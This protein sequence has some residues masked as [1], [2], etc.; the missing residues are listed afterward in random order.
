M[1]RELEIRNFVPKDFW[2][3][4]A[5]FEA[6]EGTYKGKW[7]RKEEGRDL[8]RF[9]PEEAARE[10]AERLRGKPGKVASVAA[11]TEK[12]RPELLYDLTNLQKE[13]NKRFGFTAEHTLEVAQ[14]LYEAKLISYPRTNS[15]CLTEA[16]AL[17]IPGWIRS[18]AQGQ[19]QALR[20]FVDQLRTRWPV[21]L[22]KRF[23]ND[24]EVEDHTALVPTENPARSLSGDRLRLYELIARRFLAAFWP[25]AGGGPHHGHHQDRTRRPSRPPAPWSRSWAGPRWIRPTPGP[26]RNAKGAEGESRGGRGGRDPAP[27]GQGP[28]VETLDLAPKAGKT[29]PPK[30]MSEADLLGAMQGAGKELDDEELKGA[31]KDCGL[32]TPATRANIIETLLKRAYVERK[33]NILQPTAKGIE[34]VKSIQAEALKSPQLTGEWEAHMERIRRGE[35]RRDAFMERH[36]RLRHRR[37]GQA[38]GLGPPGPRRLPPLRPA[39]APD[40]LHHPRS[41]LPPLRPC[42]TTEAVLSLRGRNVRRAILLRTAQSLLGWAPPPSLPAADMAKIDKFLQQMVNKGAA[43]L[44]LDPGDVPVVEVAGGHRIALSTQEMLGTVLDGLAKEILPED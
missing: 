25:D 43:V 34:L 30:R 7:F 41:L 36:P 26:G 10:L 6:E 4:W 44:R 37:G 35:A 40:P 5:E 24:K 31:M 16:D 32:G 21:K 18:L 14:E 42:G 19:L 23:V 15:R 11:R 1:N 17:K 8:D 39:H 3:L 2:T 22:D 38:P 13:A 29:T 27:R 20:P 28:G 9:D 33:R 12:K